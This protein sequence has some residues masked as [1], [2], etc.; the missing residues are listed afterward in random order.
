[1]PHDLLSQRIATTLK[2]EMARRDVTQESLAR[3][4]GVSQ[5]FISRRLSGR[6]TLSVDELSDIAVAIGVPVADLIALDEYVA[7]RDEERAS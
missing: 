5:Q 7:K 1:M 2:A 4:L 3:K 6:V